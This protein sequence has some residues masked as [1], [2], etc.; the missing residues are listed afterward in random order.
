MKQT[1]IL[2]ESEEQLQ[3]YIYLEKFKEENLLIFLFSDDPLEKVKTIIKEIKRMLPKALILGSSS[4]GIIHKG[5]SVSGKSLITFCQFK[6]IKPKGIILSSENFNSAEMALE[7]KKQII[8]EDSKMLFLFDDG[9]EMNSSELLY[10]ISSILPKLPLAGG[11]AANENYILGDT[12]IFLN[13]EIITKGAAAVSLNGEYLR[14]SQQYRL[15]W[16]KIGKKMKIKNAHRFLLICSICLLPIGIV[17]GF[18]VPTL[19]AYG[20]IVASCFIMMAASSA[21]SI[22]MMSYVQK[23]TPAH[24]VGKIMSFTMCICMVAQPLGQA[25]YGILFEN[26]AGY[27]A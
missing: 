7:I 16:K 14:V 12:Y 18:S 3:N 21:F 1:S 8:S 10:E 19:A 13:E 2:Y 26:L 24:L 5:N 23:V 4:G 25:M 17:L 9:T 22:Q 6:M 11:K 15:N 27:T 20:V